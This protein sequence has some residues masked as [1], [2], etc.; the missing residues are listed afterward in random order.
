MAIERIAALS[1][2]VDLLRYGQV[3]SDYTHHYRVSVPGEPLLAPAALFKWYDM[4]HEGQDVPQDLDQEARELL[5][6]DPLFGNEDE[7]A[8]HGLGVVVAHYVHAGAIL[9]AGVW[10]NVNELWT[11]VWFREYGDGA[12][13]VRVGRGD[14]GPAFCVWELGSICHERAAW[15]T[16]LFSDQDTAARL[17]WLD[18]MYAGRV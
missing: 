18:D 6:Q 2:A 15:H 13:Y 1:S 17:V 3:P 7:V 8:G 5:L 10:N 9:I 14:F 16:Y 4:V 12:P 11:S